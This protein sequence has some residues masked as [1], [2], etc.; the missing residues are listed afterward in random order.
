[1]GEPHVV[2][3]LEMH[4]T[5]HVDEGDSFNYSLKEVKKCSQPTVAKGLSEDKFEQYTR[6][7]VLFDRCPAFS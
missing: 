1:M 4:L 5:N 6:A 7:E 3:K 2:T